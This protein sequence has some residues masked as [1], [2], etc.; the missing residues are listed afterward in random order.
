MNIN[1]YLGTFNCMLLIKESLSFSSVATFPK[2]K[3]VMILCYLL[4]FCSPEK[5]NSAGTGGSGNM[6]GY[7]YTAF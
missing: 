1:I 4:S 3:T 7:P 5:S 6:L 2:C